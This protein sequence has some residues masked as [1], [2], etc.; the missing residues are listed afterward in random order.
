MFAGSG[1]SRPAAGW[2]RRLLTWGGL[3]TTAAAT[4]VIGGGR[5]LELAGHLYL[6]ALAA[7]GAMLLAGA[8]LGRFLSEPPAGLVSR[9]RNRP[10]PPAAG[11]LRSLEE[12]ERAF[13]FAAATAFDVHYRLRPRL[14]PIARHR[15]GVRGVS[16]DLEP[17]LSRGVLGDELWQL[18]RPDRD[19]P[20]DRNGRGLSMAQLRELVARLEAV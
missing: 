20:A 18:V 16:L 7:I 10:R 9:R 17:G 8:A 1:S 19:P 12:L 5:R 6:V 13:D 4:Y 3:A 2:L 14:V 11:R 15:L